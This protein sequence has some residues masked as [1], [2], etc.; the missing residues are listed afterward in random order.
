MG[1]RLTARKERETRY[2][3]RVSERPYILLL[4][5]LNKEIKYNFLASITSRFRHGILFA[6]VYSLHD[7]VI[8][9]HVINM[10]LW[11][12]NTLMVNHPSWM[13]LTQD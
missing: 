4:G 12:R 2:M 6:T 5:V 11:A 1:R 7:H 10:H 3:I 9:R 8:S 13:F